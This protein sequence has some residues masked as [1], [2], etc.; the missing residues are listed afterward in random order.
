MS[1]TPNNAE[2]TRQ[3]Q[4]LHITMT[5]QIEKLSTEMCKGF[6][7]VH[8]RQDTTNGKVSE[9]AKFRVEAQTSLSIFKWLFGALGM[10]NI[11]LLI[12]IFFI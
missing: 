8:L 1:D 5:E 2:L 6:T 11:A 9:N 7:G 3:I 10:G 4:S 12:K